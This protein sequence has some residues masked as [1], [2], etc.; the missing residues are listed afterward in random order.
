MMLG[1]LQ[2]LLRSISS[3]S[4]ALNVLVSTEIIFLSLF[5]VSFKLKIY[6]LK[7]KFGLFLIQS[8]IKVVLIFTFYWDPNDANSLLI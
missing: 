2:N 7:L 6:K 3:A 5:I 8:I 1:V 4:S